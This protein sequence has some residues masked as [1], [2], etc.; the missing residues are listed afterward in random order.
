[1]RSWNWAGGT[2]TGRRVPQ[3][4]ALSAAVAI[5]ATIVS[6]AP[7]DSCFAMFRTLFGDAYPFTYDFEELAVCPIAVVVRSLKILRA[8]HL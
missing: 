5:S 4:D 7:L 6:R 1:M 8:S 2:L 3:A